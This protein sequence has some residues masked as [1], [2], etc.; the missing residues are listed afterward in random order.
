MNRL[1]R[2]GAAS[3]A[4]VL[5]LSLAGC[6]GTPDQGGTSSAATTTTAAKPDAW[7]LFKTAAEKSGALTS[8]NADYT[9][10]VKVEV[11]GSAIATNISGNVKSSGEG[12][13]RKAAVTGT[14][15]MLG[16]SVPMA[17]YYADGFSYAETLGMKIKTPVSYEDFAGEAGY[18]FA[19]T[20]EMN[21]T[22]F[23]SA[24]VTE[25]NGLTK[26]ALPMSEALAKKL[27]G[28]AAESAAEGLGETKFTDFKAVFVIDAAGYLSE[29]TVDCTAS[30]TMD[31]SDPT[32][33]G[34]ESAAQQEMTMVINMAMKYVNPGEE[35]TVTLPENLDEYE[36]MGDLSGLDA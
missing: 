30:A 10:K 33:S 17:S 25:E 7:A 12:D 21:E 5:L 6:S 35:V 31:L 32:G 3:L 19:D 9:V 11:E 22:D 23:K 28:T 34:D 18:S 4:A 20:D 16:Q 2:I 36:D 15:E 24:A 1:F 26:I 13:A 29:M 27:A 14:M 8:V